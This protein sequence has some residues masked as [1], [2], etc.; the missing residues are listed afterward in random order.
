MSQKKLTDEL[1]RVGI[2]LERADC[3]E[4]PS[5]RWQT[6]PIDGT[7]WPYDYFLKLE[8]VATFWIRERE[9]RLRE[10]EVGRQISKMLHELTDAEVQE[11]ARYTSDQASPA[12]VI[13]A[14]ERARLVPFKRNWRSEIER[15]SKQYGDVWFCWTDQAIQEA[16]SPRV[17]RRL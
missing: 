15:F 13:C 6:R 9:A 14:W 12:Y 3:P 8:N 11:L 5:H 17:G 16:I 7:P 1:K 4:F 2:A 10:L